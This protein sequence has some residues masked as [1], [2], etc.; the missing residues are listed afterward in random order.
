MPE[1]PHARSE[2]PRFGMLQ[3]IDKLFWPKGG[4]QSAGI[5]PIAKINDLSNQATFILE[6]IVR[7]LPPDIPGE[8]A[9]CL[10][11]CVHIDLPLHLDNLI[12][13]HYFRA[14][15]S[16]GMVNHGL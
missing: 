3:G 6:R 10:F 8:V 2:P 12:I 7:R 15:E 11:L 4:F 9:Q 16:Q 14:S 13:T 5:F 1:M